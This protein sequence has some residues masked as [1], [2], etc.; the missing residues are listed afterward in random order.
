MQENKEIR[1][2]AN[3][4]DGQI[5]YKAIAEAFNLDYISIEKF[6]P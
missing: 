2:G 3:V 5:T 6:L 4:V 1:L